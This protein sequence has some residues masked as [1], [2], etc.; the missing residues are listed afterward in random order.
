MTWLVRNTSNSTMIFEPDWSG[1]GANVRPNEH[2]DADRVFGDRQ[3]ASIVLNRWLRS[4]SMKTM[5]KD[6][7]LATDGLGR[8]FVRYVPDERSVDAISRGMGA[9]QFVHGGIYLATASMAA[10]T[11]GVTMFK[12]DDDN[13]DHLLD[14]TGT[15][16]IPWVAAPGDWLTVVGALRF[17]S[18]F[19]R[20]FQLVEP[21]GHRGERAEI[22]DWTCTD[23]NG[24]NATI[25][26]FHLDESLGRS[27]WPSQ[28]RI[29]ANWMAPEQ[30][31][32]E[33]MGENWDVW[34]DI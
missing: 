23:G 22:G 25:S 27:M 30:R 8:R 31:R 11:W 15:E 3:H 12:W 14:A 28:G 6:S 7:P 5:F 16:V 29:P 19:L 32:I 20:E 18:D 17:D 9:G 10:A 24:R 34:E 4:G 1:G 26:L 21:S 13:G 2:I 33:E